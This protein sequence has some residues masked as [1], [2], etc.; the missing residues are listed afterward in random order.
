MKVK[1][2]IACLLATLISVLATVTVAADTDTDSS[3]TAA[4]GLRVS[5]A[6]E[7]NRALE[8]LSHAQMRT[9]YKALKV[10]ARAATLA[11]KKKKREMAKAKFLKETTTVWESCPMFKPT[12]E[13]SCDHNTSYNCRYGEKC[14]DADGFCKGK[15]HCECVEGKYSCTNTVKEGACNP[16]KPLTKNRCKELLNCN[17]EGNS[18][19]PVEPNGPATWWGT[20]GFKFWNLRPIHGNEIGCWNVSEV[21]NMDRA[22]Q[23]R[24][25]INTP[26]CW[27]VSKVTSMSEMFNYGG[28]DQDI[29]FWDV[30]SVTNFYRMFQNNT[31]DPDDV[32]AYFNLEDEDTEG[33]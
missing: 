19:I 28:F 6:K 7:E 17:L 22:F 11:V 5:K 13:H 12:S 20:G 32:R 16:C 26:L 3:A 1:G 29:S 14:E 4:H 15:K 33:L 31:L 9:E 24:R 2:P 30:S 23:Y 8:D 21:T 18:G 25:G 10:E 27:D